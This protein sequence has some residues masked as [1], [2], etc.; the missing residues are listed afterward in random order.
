M[1]EIQRFTA[2]AS[3]ELRTP[4]AVLRSEAESALR[5]RRTPEEYEH[6]LSIV[7]E[8][9]TRLGVPCRSIAESEST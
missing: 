1:D 8:E 3:H 4:L 6:T 5:K 9:A 2:D 7:M